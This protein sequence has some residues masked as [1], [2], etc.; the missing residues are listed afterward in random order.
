MDK[1]KILEQIENSFEQKNP[2]NFEKLSQIIKVFL[3]LI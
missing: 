2:F 1:L 3:R